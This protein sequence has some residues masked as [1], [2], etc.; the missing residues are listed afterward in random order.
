MSRPKR[1]HRGSLYKKDRSPYW[2]AAFTVHGHRYRVSTKETKREAAELKRAE[3]ILNCGGAPP[4]KRPRRILRNPPV[5]VAIESYV[6]HRLAA[7]RKAESYERLRGPWCAKLGDLPIGDVT[8][9]LVTATLDE[10]T[11][12]HGWSAATRSTALAELSGALTHARRRGWIAEHPIRDGRVPKPDVDNARER[13]LVPDEIEAIKRHAAPWL[14]DVIDFAVKTC[15]RL[16]EITVL[17]RRNTLVDIH[18][19]VFLVTERTKNRQRVRIPL[20]GELAELVRGKRIEAPDDDA[21]LFPGPRGGDARA[22]IRRGFRRAVEAAKLPYGR[23][24]DGITFHTLRHSGASILANAGVRLEAIMR[25][26]N[27][28]DRRMV[29]RYMHLG[30]DTLAAAMETLDGIV[31]AAG[32]P[33][34]E[35][36][37]TGA[38][39]LDVQATVN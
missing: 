39:R 15:R 17:R 27:W 1:K 13:W 9:E 18:G 24:R 33:T 25:I 20:R 35:R 2:Q 6:E 10:L 7:G 30:D 5:F 22:S 37:D 11:R 32:A 4:P 23:G 12:E 28:R 3:L 8:S 19:N 34:P 31:S 21:R 29:E 14:A 38:E 26:G 36:P 16:G